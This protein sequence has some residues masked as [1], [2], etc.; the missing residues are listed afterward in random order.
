MLA[1]LGIFW[2][3]RVTD[4]SEKMKIFVCS[5][6]Q[7]FTDLVWLLVLLG[8]SN[9][10]NQKVEGFTGSECRNVVWGRQFHSGRL[11]EALTPTRGTGCFQ[12]ER[13]QIIILTMGSWVRWW[14]G[15]LA[16]I[17]R[18]S[19]YSR[20]PVRIFHNLESGVKRVDNQ[21]RFPANYAVWPIWLSKKLAYVS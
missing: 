8:L 17:E 2:L 1:W 21:I 14:G 4:I 5:I 11:F 15:G 20:Y 6:L 19:E 9:P 7:H 18:M 10:R 13:C 12:T 3:F 16:P